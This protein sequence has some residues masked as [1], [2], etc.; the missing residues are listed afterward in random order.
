MASDKF[1]INIKI[2]G[3]FLVFFKRIFH[4]NMSPQV[5]SLWLGVVTATM[6][7]IW[8]QRNGYKFDDKL[9]NLVRLRFSVVGWVKEAA[10]IAKGSMHNSIHDFVIIKN[11]GV[12]CKSSKAPRIVEIKWYPLLYGWV[13]CNMDGLSKNPSR[14][15][16]CGG[17]FWD[18]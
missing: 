15:A 5:R 17:L 2:N 3:S 12:Q 6:W 14:L 10:I 18:H 1:L 7:G 9:S 4:S 16:A 8:Y 13:K 11:F